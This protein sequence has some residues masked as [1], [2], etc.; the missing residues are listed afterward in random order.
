MNILHF[1][2]SYVT[3]QLSTSGS[4]RSVSAFQYIVC[5]CSTQHWRKESNRIGYFNTSYVTVQPIYIRVSTQEQAKFQYIVCYCSTLSSGG[6]L[7]SIALFQYIVCYC[8]TN[9]DIE[10]HSIFMLFQ[11]IVCYCSTST[12]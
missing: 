11:Y 6:D 5:Y 2:T 4:P 1:N 8:S 12:G 7:T 10:N 3:V 9:N